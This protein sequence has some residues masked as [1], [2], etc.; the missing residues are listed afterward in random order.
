MLEKYDKAKHDPKAVMDLLGM[1]VGC[2]TP[3][4][5][6]KLLEVVY[7]IDGHELFVNINEGLITGVI[8]VDESAPPHGWILHLAVQPDSRRRG[9][10]RKIIND[11]METLALE[12][13]GLETDREAVGFYRACG[14]EVIEIKSPWPGVQRFRCTRGNPP[15]SVLEYYSN[16]KPL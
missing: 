16:K 1:A 9:T 10:G 4:R 11:L 12:S 8:G 6:Y 14:F 2:P 13:V 7:E 3:E 5:L 15:Q